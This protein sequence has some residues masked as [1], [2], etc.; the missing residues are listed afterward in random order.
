MV[1]DGEKKRKL[2]ARERWLEMGPLIKKRGEEN[3][4]GRD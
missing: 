4:H 2:K 1:S 3:S